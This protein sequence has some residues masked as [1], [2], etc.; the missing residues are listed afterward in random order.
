MRLTPPSRAALTIRVTC[1]WSH[2]APKNQYR[3]YFPK[4]D[5]GDFEA[6]DP[7]PLHGSTLTAGLSSAT[8]ASSSGAV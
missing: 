5:D 2:L 7:A 4:S 8:H 1:G 6:A 3:S